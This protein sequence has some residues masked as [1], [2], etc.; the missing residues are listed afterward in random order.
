M[1]VWNTIKSWFGCVSS[2]D[3]E[4]KLPSPES[5]TVENASVP[6]TQDAT[7]TDA[8]ASALSPAQPLN[9]SITGQSQSADNR[10]ASYKEQQSIDAS[11]TSRSYTPL[12]DSSDKTDTSS[13]EDQLASKAT[14]SAAKGDAAATPDLSRRLMFQDGKIVGFANTIRRYKSNQPVR[15]NEIPFEQR[16]DMMLEA[17]EKHKHTS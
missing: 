10:Q 12:A 14:S 1:K 8:Q 9:T 6:V 7:T 4:R 13:S 11:S 5:N 15:I 2:R 3:K 17:E 16:L